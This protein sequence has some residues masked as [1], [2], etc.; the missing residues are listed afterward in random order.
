M[1]QMTPQVLEV[2]DKALALSEEERG[3][4]IAR[5][6]QSLGEEPA[7]EEVEEAWATEIQQR[8]DDVRSGR[9]KTIPSEEVFRELEEEFPDVK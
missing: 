5:L 6:N 7:E 8:V 9:V 1:A 4:V 2:L 3:L